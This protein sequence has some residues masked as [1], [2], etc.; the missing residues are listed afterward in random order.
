MFIYNFLGVIRLNLYVE[1]VVRHDFHDRSFFTE[2][3]TTGCDDLN[4]VF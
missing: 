3:E 1:G 4:F 2:T